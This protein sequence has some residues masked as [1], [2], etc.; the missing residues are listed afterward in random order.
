MVQI[1]ESR[2]SSFLHT[3]SQ[4]R[5]VTNRQ[6]SQRRQQSS[7]RSPSSSNRQPS[8]LSRHSSSTLAAAPGTSDPPQSPDGANDLTIQRLLEL[9]QGNR[10]QQ[11]RERQI[12]ENIS[13]R[14]QTSG[15]TAHGQSERADREEM[16]GRAAETLERLREEQQRRRVEVMELR[17]TIQRLE[18]LRTDMQGRPTRVGQ[19]N[20]AAGYHDAEES[21]SNE[22]SRPLL[23]RSRGPGH[24]AESEIQNQFHR[25][26][27]GLP[28]R[29]QAPNRHATTIEEEAAHLDQ[30]SNLDLFHPVPA[31]MGRPRILPD[32]SVGEN[33]N[34]NQP[35][36][37]PANAQ[38][39]R[40]I[41]NLN[42][43]LR[44]H[45]RVAG[46]APVSSSSPREF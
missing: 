42:R 28:P 36:V 18:Q 39:R 26:S 22:E 8:P 35:R 11:A 16:T 45:R 40:R 23:A 3:E 5:E 31:R 7:S 38:Q 6:S 32:F 10:D 43:N 29:Q 44:H 37:R 2:N 33:R 27:A 12:S 17:E 34:Q 14:S 9:Y 20:R 46:V 24:A 25:R 41:L 21:G 15:A 1:T 4:S 19:I 30:L 13:Y